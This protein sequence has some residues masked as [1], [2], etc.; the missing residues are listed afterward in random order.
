M[1]APSAE[2][3]MRSRYTAYTLDLET[4][5][6]NTWHPKTRPAS[7]NLTDFD[8]HIFWLGLQVKQSKTISEHEATVEF[9]A[10]FKDNSQHGKAERM[11]EI[12]QF[13]RLENTW[14]YVQALPN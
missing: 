6:L 12:S 11:H 2:T 5:L 10:R 3:L 7:L 14:F 8:R 9:I 1:R 13:L 4:Y